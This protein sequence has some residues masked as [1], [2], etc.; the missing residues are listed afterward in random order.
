MVM[1]YAQSRG[2]PLNAFNHREA[3]N[4]CGG[5][6]ETRSLLPGLSIMCAHVYLCEIEVKRKTGIDHDGRKCTLEVKIQ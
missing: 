5:H 4:S 3:R 6:A 2:P 1:D